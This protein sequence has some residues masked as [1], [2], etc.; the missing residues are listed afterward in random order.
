MPVIDLKG[1]WAIPLRYRLTAIVVLLEAFFMF[2][3]YSDWGFMMTAFIGIVN[4]CF[5][6]A[7]YYIIPLLAEYIEQDFAYDKVRVV[8]IGQALKG[9][10]TGTLTA[11][12]IAVA[13][14]SAAYVLL[15]TLLMRRRE[16]KTG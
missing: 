15:H 13:K 7:I 1:I 12:K 10:I 11:G 4:I 6:A 2:D 14:L 9:V 16:T 8:A 5:A 3:T